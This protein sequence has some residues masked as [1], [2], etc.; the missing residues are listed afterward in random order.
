VSVDAILEAFNV[1]NCANDQ[2]PNNV[3]TSPTL[4]RPNAVNDS[5]QLQFGFRL[6]F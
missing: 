2:V 6:R 1:L 3:I 5:R 4:G